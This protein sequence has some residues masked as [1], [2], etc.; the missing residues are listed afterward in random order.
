MRITSKGQVTISQDI[1]DLA[2]FQPGT[3][4]DFVMGADGVVRVVAAGAAPDRR[5]ADMARAIS[6][7]RGSGTTGLSSAEILALTRP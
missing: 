4:V 3:D 5:S 1:R 6:G 7:L 2:G